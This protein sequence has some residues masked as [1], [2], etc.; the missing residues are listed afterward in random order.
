MNATRDRDFKDDYDDELAEY[1][2]KQYMP[3]KRK[4]TGCCTTF[5]GCCIG[6]KIEETENDI[7]NSDRIINDL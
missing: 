6:G 7:D 5:F 2:P 4:Q 1:K 3:K